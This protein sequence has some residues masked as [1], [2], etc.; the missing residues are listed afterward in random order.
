MAA[1]RHDLCAGLRRQRG[2]GR[3]NEDAAIPDGARRFHAGLAWSE[4]IVWTE[5]TQFDFY[6]Q[7]PQV[8]IAVDAVAAHFQRTL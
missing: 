3:H 5:G 7:E 8:T 4:D 1:R 6:D 2:G